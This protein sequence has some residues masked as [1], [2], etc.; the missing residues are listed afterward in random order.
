M[1]DTVLAVDL[2]G[3]RFRAGVAPAR[4]PLAVEAVGEW[5]APRDR[6]SFLALVSEQLQKAGANHL[7]IGVP[8]LA[9]GTTCVWIPNLPYLD[10][11]DLAAAFSGAR[12]A[13]GNDAQFALVAEAT[14]G[15]AKGLDDAVLLAIGT[16]IGSA[17]L[18]GGQ[19]VT[20]SGGGAC[21][22][23]W[24]AA[25]VEDPGEDVSGW[26]ERHASGRALDAVAVRLGLTDGTTL[27]GAARRG[28]A[29]ALSALEPPMQALGTA[30][31]G[32]V[33]LLDPSVVILAGGV[34]KSLDVL[35]PMILAPLRRHL[36]KHLRGIAL[37]AGQ[38]G[39]RAGLVGA[40]VAGS[41]GPE[42][43]RQNG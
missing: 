15:A 11:L 8:G 42:W 37:K 31:A 41:R 18:A 10:G 9:R 28:D 39:A 30:L 35:E 40:A 26:L 5:P 13:L 1:S 25:D 16:G 2:G 19:I 14:A 43:R 32:A 17:V 12:V 34:V 27:V 36:P 3:T 24:A 38:F 21:S 20:G 33:A 6:E 7:G 22:F 23:G 29:R 4:D